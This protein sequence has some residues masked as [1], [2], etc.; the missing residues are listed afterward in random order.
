MGPFLELWVH[1]GDCALTTVAPASATAVVMVVTVVGVGPVM[2]S[3]FS[4]GRK[5]RIVLT[6][7]LTVG[8][9]VDV[10]VNL[11]LFQFDGQVDC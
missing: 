8:L 10:G 7:F 6:W 2:A 1:M 5:E 11:E 3:L 4:V 9:C